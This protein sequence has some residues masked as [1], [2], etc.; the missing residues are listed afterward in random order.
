[1][2]T[3]P[4]TMV[5][6]DDDGW[7]WMTMD[8]DENGAILGFCESLVGCSWPIWMILTYQGQKWFQAEFF[9]GGE[10]WGYVPKKM[11]RWSRLVWY[12]QKG[13]K[14]HASSLEKVPD[15]LLPM[16]NPWKGRNCW[17]HSFMAREPHQ[18]RWI[19][20]MILLGT[21]NYMFGRRW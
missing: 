11:C 18:W 6:V 15:M 12:Q 1:M 9:F 3:M 10:N 16:L 13:T 4:T 7:W 8:M 14:I 5:M 21:W 20:V 17:R 2:T 19:D